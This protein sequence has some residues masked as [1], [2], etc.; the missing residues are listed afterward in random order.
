MVPKKITT[1]PFE[2][3]K[4][5]D[6]SH[7]PFL[8]FFHSFLDEVEVGRKVSFLKG[9]LRTSF[10]I[11]KPKVS[12][13]LFENFTQQISPKPVVVFLS[14]TSV[15]E[16]ILVEIDSGL[17]MS[18]ADLALGGE[19]EVSNKSMTVLEEGVL[20]FLI[21][22]VLK[23]LKLAGSTRFVKIEKD[24]KN[25]SA[26]FEEK[27][28]LFSVHLSVVV[29]PFS[30]FIRFLFPTSFLIENQ[31]T[32]NLPFTNLASK[33]PEL[34]TILWAEAGKTVLK[35][36]EIQNLQAG[37]IVLLAETSILKNKNIEG[38]V[39][40]HVGEE[41]SGEIPALISEKEGRFVMTLT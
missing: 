8:S 13:F 40:L 6:S 10:E 20:E 31:K 24:P 2:T 21:L 16:K 4:S 23:E 28:R 25:I 1:F 15:C 7:L 34:K 22:K 12:S 38:Q 33:W 3:L 41:K 19:G 30:G 39:F 35:P 18:V 37:D 29:G 26:S 14:N 11:G 27:E 36:T 32:Q 9:L 5:F 17:A